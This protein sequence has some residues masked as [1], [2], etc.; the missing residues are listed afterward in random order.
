[1]SAAEKKVVYISGPITGVENYWEAFEQAEDDLEAV[2]YTALSPAR[3]PKGMTNEQYMQIDLAMLGAADAVLF[4]LGWDNSEG[5]TVEHEL[6]KYMDKPRVY[7]RGRVLG[8]DVDPVEERRSWL[9][10]DLMEVI[11]K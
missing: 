10:M 3:L 4:L 9:Y 6:A 11:G 8:D 5:A 2:G 7:Q 1:M